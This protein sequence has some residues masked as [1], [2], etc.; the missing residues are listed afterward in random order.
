M[1]ARLVA[2]PTPTTLLP[3]DAHR[4]RE[5]AATL[6]AC[7]ATLRALRKSRERD[8]LVW[9]CGVVRAQRATTVAAMHR[10]YVLLF[11]LVARVNRLALAAHFPH[12]P[13]PPRTSPNASDE[14]AP[15]AP[16][17]PLSP[18]PHAVAAAHV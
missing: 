13:S 12:A 4:W 5:F 10:T 11:R 14:D 16:T 9:R 2:Y 18:P 8:W 15:P 3:P 7:H 17:L 1:S 6:R